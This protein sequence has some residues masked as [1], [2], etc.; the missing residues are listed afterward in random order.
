MRFVAVRLTVVQRLQLLSGGPLVSVRFFSNKLSA[1]VEKVSWQQ[2]ASQWQDQQAEVDLKEDRGEKLWL[3]LH[4]VVPGGCIYLATLA[5]KLYRYT[6]LIGIVWKP[7][8]NWKQI[9]TRVYSHATCSVMLKVGKV[10]LRWVRANIRQLPINRA[11]LK[12]LQVFS[13][14]EKQK[15]L[16]FEDQLSTFADKISHC[17]LRTE[18]QI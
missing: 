7:E 2:E 18:S 10:V 16:Q 9:R 5:M 15:K 13:E 6:R 14:H 17:A 1:V 11:W 4:A 8:L 3:Q 12:V